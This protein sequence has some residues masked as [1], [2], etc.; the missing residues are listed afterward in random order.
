MTDFF[1]YFGMA[2][3]NALR[4]LDNRFAHLVNPLAIGVAISINWLL[5]RSHYF[6]QILSG[7]HFYF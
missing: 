1:P 6:N 4:V 7:G 5:I 2:L 3:A